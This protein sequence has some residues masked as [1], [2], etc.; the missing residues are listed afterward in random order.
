MNI[1]TVLSC[2]A[3]VAGLMTSAAAEL[4]FQFSTNDA[5]VFDLSGSWETNSE[6]VDE[7]FTINVTPRGRI[8]GPFSASGDQDGVHIDM[9]GELSGMIV[10]TYPTDLRMSL[11]LRGDFTATV[12]GMPVRGRERLHGVFHAS[13]ATG[14]LSGRMSGSVCVIGVRCVPVQR[15]M[16]IPLLDSM[17]AGEGDGSWSLTLNID[18]AKNRVTG[19]ATATM[20]NERT[21]PFL[22]NGTISSR[23]GVTK[24]R[25]RGT[26]EA[27]G[28]TLLAQLNSAQ[29]ITS[30][31]GRLFGQRLSWRA[32]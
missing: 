6:G 29:E 20:P 26:G 7:V 24:L 3:L 31:Q 8:S 2:A 9:S 25:L 11:G 19:T 5:P 32:E 4:T 12:N 28:V 13:E 22:V 30:L 14:T 17:D 1:R 10:A 15:S 16:E 27:A 21:V 18:A 23:T